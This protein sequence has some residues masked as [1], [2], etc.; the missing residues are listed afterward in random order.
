MITGLLAWDLGRLF[1]ARAMLDAGRSAQDILAETRAWRERDVF[2]ARA[3]AATESTLR[4]MHALLRDADA[5]LKDNGD[6]FEILTTLIARLALAAPRSK[7][8]SGKPARAFAR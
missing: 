4:R 2:M 7:P 1:K 5:Q 6:P 8:G 3:R